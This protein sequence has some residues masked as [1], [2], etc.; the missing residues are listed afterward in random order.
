MLTSLIVVLGL[1]K[2]II[3]QDN[4]LITYDL[5]AP[6]LNRTM[7]LTYNAQLS[8]FKFN[9]CLIFFTVTSIDF[10]QYSYFIMFCIYLI[11]LMKL[12]CNL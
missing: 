3:Y 8:L 10:I 1:L 2:L 12:P 11:L 7:R 9:F 6:R 5:V 4:E